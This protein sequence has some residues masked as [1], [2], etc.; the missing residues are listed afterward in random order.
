VARVEAGGEAP[1]MVTVAMPHEQEV[2]LPAP[3]GY[4]VEHG[5]DS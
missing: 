1:V 2:T 4:V 3:L 5:L